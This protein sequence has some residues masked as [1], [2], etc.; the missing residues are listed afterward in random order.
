MRRCLVS[1]AAVLAIT[2]DAVHAQVVD[3]G[4]FS[5]SEGGERLGR[6]QFSIRHVTAGVTELRAENAVG[7]RRNAYRLE[8]DSLGA[9]I[10]YAVEV[11]DGDDIVLRLGGQRVRGRFTTL[12]RGTNGESAR[13]YLIGDGVH[14]LDD[15]AV[16]Q[17]AS[18]LSHCLALGKGESVNMQIIAPMANHQGL[19]R[20]ILEAEDDAVVIAGVRRRASRWRIEPANGEP[21]LAWTDSEGRL[22]RLVIPSR[23]FEALRDDVP[24]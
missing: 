8:V 3:V 21:H 18:L 20:V 15:G 9:P 17:F 13:E 24:R 11:R 14:V 16:H 7:S 12:A 1:L 2:A 19:L 22:L 4:S 5:I 23:Q 6:E 10:R